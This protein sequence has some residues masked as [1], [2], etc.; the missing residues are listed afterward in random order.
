MSEQRIQNCK[1]ITTFALTHTLAQTEL[2]ATTTKKELERDLEK[3]TTKNA[4][5]TINRLQFTVS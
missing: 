2:F 4:S 5:A 3:D 1:N